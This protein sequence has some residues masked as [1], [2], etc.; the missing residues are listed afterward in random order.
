MKVVFIDRDGVINRYPG[1]RQYV[2]N[3]KDF[4]FVPGSIEGIRKLKDKGFKVFVV[5]NQAG[6]SKGLYTEGDLEKMD[7][8][9]LQAL[10]KKKASVEGVY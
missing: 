2:T 4:E 1:P 10:K 6:V 3:V 9:L 7:K 5:S 8:K